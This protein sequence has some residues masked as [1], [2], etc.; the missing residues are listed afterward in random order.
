MDRIGKWAGINW[1]D[2]TG[3]QDPTGVNPAHQAQPGF[4][5]EGGVG[6]GVGGGFGERVQLLEGFGVRV[7]EGF[8]A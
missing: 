6:N 1:G 2:S 8:G 3:G 5:A 4:G 7:G